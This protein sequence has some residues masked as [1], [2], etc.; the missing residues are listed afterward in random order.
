MAEPAIP[1]TTPTSSQQFPDPEV[2]AAGN[3]A[4][5][6][7]KA[8]VKAPTGHASS[9]PVTTTPGGSSFDA[10][11]GSVGSNQVNIAA[12]VA[13]IRAQIAQGLTPDL[14]SLLDQRDPITGK[15]IRGSG[16]TVTPGKLSVGDITYS[17]HPRTVE[18]M[19]NDLARWT[20]DELKVMQQR[21]YAA[22]YY[23]TSY[24]T[25]PKKHPVPFGVKNDQATRGAFALLI[26]DGLLFH[27]KTLDA[28][29]TQNTVNNAQALAQLG[30]SSHVH[31]GVVGGGNVYVNQV[32]DPAQ[33]R[34]LADAVATSVLGRVLTDADKAKYVKL[35][36][37][38]EVQT[39]QVANNAREQ[40]ERKRFGIQAANSRAADAGA[41]SGDAYLAPTTITQTAVDPQA[42]LTE[43]IRKD[44]AAEAGAHDLGNV[45]EGF[46]SMVGL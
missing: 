10:G 9:S 33:V 43:G 23:P 25:D 2:V 46:R 41:S 1:G 44:N 3:K 26:S 15:Q 18:G 36:Q 21:L 7:K 40:A 30:A 8:K 6:T 38:H 42:D 19:L 13:A 39:Q 14:S 5:A 27:D 11:L 35:V 37:Q 20:P 12:K 29:L 45:Y 32:D 17:G 34:T 31:Q 22:G 24:Y 28:I 16:A 4:K